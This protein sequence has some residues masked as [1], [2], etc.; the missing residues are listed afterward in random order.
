MSHTIELV[1]GEEELASYFEDQ[2]LRLYAH[3]WHLRRGTYFLQKPGCSEPLHATVQPSGCAIHD[4]LWVQ[5]HGLASF[6][7]VSAVLLQLR[8]IWG[9]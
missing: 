1:T 8:G 6:G 5:V 4:Y 7:T 3:I 2:A 9:R